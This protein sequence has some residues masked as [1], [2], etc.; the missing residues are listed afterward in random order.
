MEYYGGNMTVTVDGITH[1]VNGK[2]IKEIFRKLN[3]QTGKN[4]LENYED[5]LAVDI[6]N[7]TEEQLEEFALEVENET[8]CDNGDIE[9]RVMN[10]MFGF[11]ED[12]E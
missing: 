8:C 4:I 12:F 7:I 5:E 2:V 10:R 3:I 11:K 6:D 1:E 9:W